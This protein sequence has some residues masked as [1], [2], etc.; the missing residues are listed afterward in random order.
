MKQ[1]DAECRNRGSNNDP[2]M[3]PERSIQSVKIDWLVTDLDLRFR[4]E[5]NCP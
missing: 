5:R 1:R 4:W 3:P 2:D